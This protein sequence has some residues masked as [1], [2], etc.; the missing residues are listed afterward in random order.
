MRTLPQLDQARP[1]LT[2]GGLETTLVFHDGIDLPTLPRSRCST[3]ARA[4]R[5]CAATTSRTSISPPGEAPGSCST[6]RPGAPTSTG[7]HGSATTR[8][9]SRRSTAV[10]SSS[11][12]A[13]AGEHPS[14]PTVVNGVIGP[15]GDGYVVGATMTAARP[16]RTTGCRPTPLPSGGR[17]DQRDH[18]DLPRR[19]HRRRPRRGRGRPAGGDLVHRRDRRSA[20]V[21]AVDRARRSTTST[22]PPTAVPPT[23]W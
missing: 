10:P 11:S 19:G 23:T 9:D 21:R 13:L 17:D 18:H 3:P 14:V 15:H 7:A 20:A 1:F 2:D 5:R 4:G 8:Y 16:P 22:V 6:R 12:H